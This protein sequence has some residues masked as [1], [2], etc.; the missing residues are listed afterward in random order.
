MFQGL[1][2]A[3]S[4]PWIT[5]RQNHAVFAEFI[6]IQEFGYSAIPVIQTFIFPVFRI[7][8]C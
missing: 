3:K 5:T 4:P 2:F 8:K 6:K 7:G 1:Q